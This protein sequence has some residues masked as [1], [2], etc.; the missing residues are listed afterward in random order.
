MEYPGKVN[1]FPT[2]SGEDWKRELKTSRNTPNKIKQMITSLI[3]EIVKDQELPHPSGT[4]A[5][6]CRDIAIRQLKGI[7]KYGQTVAQ[8]PLELRQWLQHAY[9]ETLDNAVYLKRA[10]QELDWKMPISTDEALN[11]SA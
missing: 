10:I 4:E 6:V 2:I 3:A 1:L 9:Q 8:N 5:A 7:A 11:Q